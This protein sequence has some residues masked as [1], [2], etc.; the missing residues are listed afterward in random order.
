MGTKVKAI[1]ATSKYFLL[2]L[3]DTVYVMHEGSKVHEYHFANYEILTITKN[4][5]NRYC[6]I[7]GKHKVNNNNKVWLFDE[8]NF[9]GHAGNIF[10][11]MGFGNMFGANL[12][13]HAN[14][15]NQMKSFPIN[16]LENV[17]W[18]TLR[19][20]TPDDMGHLG[21]HTS[22]EVPTTLGL[23]MTMQMDYLEKASN[24]LSGKSNVHV[25]NKL[26]EKE[27]QKQQLLLEKKR[28][29]CYIKTT[30]NKM[31]TFTFIK[32]DN[33]FEKDPKI[34]EAAHSI[35]DIGPQQTLSKI[36]PLRTADRDGKVEMRLI[37][38]SHGSHKVAQ[39]N[40]NAVF[41]KLQD[42]QFIS[43]Y[44]SRSLPKNMV[45]NGSWI[46]RNN[47]K[48][49]LITDEKAGKHWI[50][51]DVTEKNFLPFGYKLYALF[52]EANV[53]T[54]EGTSTSEIL[55]R[56]HDHIGNQTYYLAGVRK[57]LKNINYNG[58]DQRLKM[59]RNANTCTIFP[60]YA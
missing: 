58:G 31:K 28:F 18:D 10:G 1:G 49:Y 47:S 24:L 51:V 48:L 53:T 57:E 26:T 7:V 36:L 55:I 25:D 2:Y 3:K 44:M 11:N 39:Y 46:G 29:R 56:T 50:P 15:G 38:Y 23:D 13:L 17:N 35:I 22:I 21:G 41:E 16:D 37:Q 4:G 45:G 32:N 12:N 27:F 6:L 34:V 30:D 33:K 40:N 14:Q 43:S 8:Q 5:D 52:L 54:F 42:V 60:A 59:I 20:F 9:G 19:C